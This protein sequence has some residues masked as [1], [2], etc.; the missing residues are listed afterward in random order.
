MIWLIAS[1]RMASIRKPISI[2]ASMTVSARTATVPPRP[3]GPAIRR[4][5]GERKD[6]AERADDQ[7]RGRAQALVQ[8]A[9]D[10]E[11]PDHPPQQIGQHQPAEQSAL[12]AA[13]R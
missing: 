2:V 3:S 5:H 8:F 12:K 7:G 4:R 10:L 13:I 9:R 11:A 6:D 1:R